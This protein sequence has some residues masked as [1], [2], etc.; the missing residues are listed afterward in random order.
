MA[1][2][3]CVSL[4]PDASCTA[5]SCAYAPCGFAS[6][7]ACDPSSTSLPCCI[8]QMCCAPRIVVRRCAMTM[9]VRPAMSLSSAPWTS[10]SLC[11]SRAEVASSR[12]STLGSLRTARAIATRCFCPP[13]SCTPPSPTVVS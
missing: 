3:I 11:A 13:D 9:V 10:L 6:S 4:E 8:T 7:S 1:D 2:G 5:M 12:R